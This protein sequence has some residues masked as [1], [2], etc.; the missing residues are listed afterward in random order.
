MYNGYKN[1]KITGNFGEKRSY[2]KPGKSHEGVDIALAMNSPINSL[3]TGTVLSVKNDPNGYGN[4]VDI[5]HG[6][7]VVTRYGHANSF[8]VKPG[9]KVKEGEQ[10]GLVGSSGRSSGPHLHVEY[11]LNGIKKN[12]M[13]LEKDMA[14]MLKPKGTLGIQDANAIESLTNEIAMGQTPQGGNPAYKLSPEE[15]ELKNQTLASLLERINTPIEIPRFTTIQD[16]FDAEK[17][18]KLGALADY[19]GNNPDATRLLGSFLGGTYL[20]TS[21]NQ[22]VHGGE[23]EAR[24]QEAQMQAEQEKAIEAQ[25]QQNNLANALYGTFAGKDLAAAKDALEREQM[26]QRFKLEEDERAWKTEEKEKDRQFEKEENKKTRENNLKIAQER[27]TNGGL[28]PTQETSIRDKFMKDKAIQDY[29]LI[30]AR[31]QDINAIKKAFKRS[32]RLNAQDQALIMNFNKV[33]DP[34]SVVRESEFARTASGQSLVDRAAGAWAKVT[35]GG[36]GLSKAEREAIYQVFDIMTDS[37]RNRARTVAQEYNDLAI[38]YN[39]NPRNIVMQYESLLNDETPTM[40]NKA[41]KGG[42]AW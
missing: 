18:D 14:N 10:I 39:T 34:I 37:A 26:A 36:S 20:D 32:G 11:L 12:P 29:K 5:D 28:T 2:Y 30:E 7:G 41:T 19:V 35:K 33:L 3:L 9:Q 25:K 22:F 4:Y 8:S 21:R 1:A 6:N 16:I 23:Q 24:R 31:T 13:E 42:R 15:Q 38:R 27:S 17:G 40:S